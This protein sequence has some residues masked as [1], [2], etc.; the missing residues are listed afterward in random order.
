MITIATTFTNSY[1]LQMF[2]ENKFCVFACSVYLY[3]VFES[4]KS[5]FL[6]GPPLT[7]W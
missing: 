5:E 6:Q 2:D 7:I 4:L 1:I 3:V